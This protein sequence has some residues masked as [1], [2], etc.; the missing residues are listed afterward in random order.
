MKTPARKTSDPAQNPLADVARVLSDVARSLE[1][2]PDLHHTVGGIAAAATDTVSGAEDAGVSLC[3]GESLRTVAATSD[4]VELVNNL[5]HELNEGPCLDALRMGRTYRIDDMS[6]ER[7][8]PRFAAAA[9]AHGIQ[10]MLGYRLFTSSRTLGALDLCSTPPSAFDAEAEIVGELFAAHAAI[11]LLGSTQHSEWQATLNS[12]DI[13]GMAKGILMNRDGLT[14]DHAFNVLVSA[15]QDTDVKVHDVA[16]WLVAQTTRHADATSSTFDVKDVCP[17]R[18]RLD[19]QS[20][21]ARRYRDMDLAE[22]AEVHHRPR[23]SPAGAAAEPTDRRVAADAT[24]TRPVRQPRS[25]DARQATHPG[26]RPCVPPTTRRRRQR[27]RA[28]RTRDSDIVSPAPS[29]RA[30]R[31]DRSVYRRRNGRRGTSKRARRSVD[32]F[33]AG[34]FDNPEWVWV[35]DRRMF[36][37]G[38]TPGGAPFGCFE[39]GLDDLG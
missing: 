1:A 5:E 36:V 39:D 33:D 10:S 4:L 9:Q 29:G 11:A 25:D 20:A 30:D 28:R 32:N 15:P 17:F 3:E 19:R 35:G 14:D 18:R 22:R 2:E 37:V 24:P 34:Q 13:I 8:W 38:Y 31:Y 26:G 7:R 27:N 23:Q 16:R 21:T 12:R 6:H